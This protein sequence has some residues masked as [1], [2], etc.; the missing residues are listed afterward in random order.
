MN[1]M[2]KQILIGL[3]VFV[4]LAVFGFAFFILPRFG[5]AKT[6]EVKVGEAIF[7]VEIAD[8]PELRSKGL[9][10]RGYLKPDEGMLFIF[11]F[12][13]NYGF[14]MKNMKFPLDIIWIKDNK[15]VGMIIG[16]EPEMEEPLTV[17]NPPE[18]I[19]KVLEIN[20]GLTQKL[21]I[22]I[23]DNVVFSSLRTK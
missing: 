6:G 20:A 7:K 12:P 2:I 17:Y 1:I 14:W 18:P 13:G 23:G 19:D 4:L 8:T 15:I 9:S 5:G 10:G 11:P 3:A 22:K 21:G 16:A